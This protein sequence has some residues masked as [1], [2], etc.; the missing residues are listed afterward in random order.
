MADREVTIKLRA[1]SD[2]SDVTKNVQILREYFKQLKMPSDAFKGFDNTFTQLEKKVETVQAKLQAGFKTGSEINSFK[3]DLADI[4]QLYA[5][6]GK[7]IQNL[8]VSDVFKGID[9]PELIKAKENLEALQKTFQELSGQNI[10]GINKAF[11]ALTN[12]GGIDKA[13]KEVQELYDS[14][15]EG[16]LDQATQRIRE[17]AKAIAGMRQDGDRAKAYKG[18]LQNLVGT[19]DVNKILNNIDQVRER[20]NQTFNGDVLNQA[21][22]GIEATEIQIENLSAEQV[23]QLIKAFEDLGLVVRTGANKEL[24]QANRNL[25]E[26][27]EASKQLNTE[28]DQFKS[29]I[30]YFFGMNNAVRLFQ[31][32]LRSAFNTVKD[33]DKVM[34]ETAVVT[35]F[36]VGDMWS[37]LPEYTARA[38]ELGLAIHDVYEASTLYYQQGLK[39]NEV[40]AVTNATLRMARIA[41]LDAADATDRVTNALRGFNMEIT[42]ANA[43]NIADVYSKLA[44]M[45]ASNVDEISTAMTKVASLANNANMNFETTA[46]FLAQ[47]IETTRESAETAGTALKTVVARFSEVKKLYSEGELLGNDEEGEEIDVNKVSTALRTAGINLNEFLTGQRGLDEIFME[48]ASKWDDLTIVQQRYIATMAAG[49]RQQSR[50]I[51]LMSDYA[52]TQELVSAAQDA[53]GASQEQYEKTLDS[54]ETKLNRLKNAWDEFVMGLAKDEVIKWVVDALTSVIGAVNSLTAALPGALKSL[55]RLAIALTA[56]KGAKAIFNGLFKNIGTAMGMQAKNAGKESAGLF[57]NGFSGALQKL[58]PSVTKVSMQELETMGQE[59]R[60]AVVDNLP[61]VATQINQLFNAGNFDGAIHKIQEFGVQFNL[62]KDKV[63]ELIAKLKEIEAAQPKA[64]ALAQFNAACQKVGTTISGIGGSLLLIGQVLRSLGLDKA[65]DTLQKIGGI[66]L[67]VGLLIPKLSTGLFELGVKL[68]IITVQEIQA[69]NAALVAGGKMATGG[70][71]A[72]VAWGKLAIILAAIALVVT[73]IVLIINNLPDKKIQKLEEHLKDVEDAASEAVDKYN[74]LN[75]SIQSITEAED[76]LGELTQGTLEWKNAVLELN[77]QYL[78]LIDKIPVLSQF[79]QTQ[80]GVLHIDFDSAEVQEALD[81]VRQDAIERQMQV[82]LARQNVAKGTVDARREAL[83]N[84]YAHYELLPQKVLDN[85]DRVALA[86]AGDAEA[87]AYYQEQYGITR[88]GM[89]DQEYY[90]AIRSQEGLNTGLLANYEK[91][92]EYGNLLI[93]QGNEIEAQNRALAASIVSNSDL[94][95][96]QVEDATELLTG[97]VLEGLQSSVELARDLSEDEYKEYEEYWKKWAASQGY[98][99]SNVRNRGGVVYRDESGERHVIRAPQAMEQYNAHLQNTQ[100]TEILNS[101]SQTIASSNFNQSIARALLN[102]SDLVASDLE[103]ITRWSLTEAWES[104]SEEEQK[105]FEND[106]EAFG[107][108]VENAKTSLEEALSKSSEIGFNFDGLDIGQG[109]ISSLNTM[110]DQYQ[111]R[112]GAATASGFVNQINGILDGMDSESQNEFLQFVSGMTNWANQSIPGVLQEMSDLGIGFGESEDAIRLF[113]QQMIELDRTTQ[114]VSFEKIREEIEATAKVLQGLGERNANDRNFTQEEYDALKDLNSDLVNDM[115]WNGTEWTYIGSD[116]NSLEDAVREATGVLL[117]QDR[118]R[119]EESV[120]IGQ[121]ISDSIE[122]ANGGT[123]TSVNGQNFSYE[124]LY[125]GN[126]QVDQGL[127]AAARRQYLES[128]GLNSDEFARM[129]SQALADYFTTQM[130]TYYG[131]NGSV[132]AENQTTLDTITAQLSSAIANIAGTPLS[133]VQGEANANITQGTNDQN[134]A[135]ILA[136]AAQFGVA[137]EEIEEFNSLL[138]E[139]GNLLEGCEGRARELLNTITKKAGLAQAAKDMEAYGKAIHDNLD[140][141][142]EFEEGSREY[143]DALQEMTEQTER[144]FGLELPEDFMSAENLQLLTEA[145]EGSDQAWADYIENINAAQA[146]EGAW[147]DAAVFDAQ[148]VQTVAAAVDGTEINIDGTADVSDIITAMAQAGASA[149]EVANF[150]NELGYAHIDFQ[151][152]G[153]ES[154]EEVI[155]AGKNGILGSI[156]AV[157]VRVPNRNSFTSGA[158]GARGGSGGG[159]GGGSK[160]SWQNPYDELYNLTEKINESIRKRNQLEEEYDR[161]LNRRDGDYEA[162][163]KNT[164]QQISLLSKELALQQQLRAGRLSQLSNVGNEKF[165]TENGFKTY[166]EMGVTRYASYNA[167]TGLLEIDWDGINQ[168]EDTETGKAVEAYVK[169]LEELEGQIEDTDKT[170]SEI[171]DQIYDLRQEGKDEAVEMENRIAEALKNQQQKI[172]DEYQALSE[173]IADSNNKVLNSLQESIDLSRQIRD[174]TKTE[175]DIAEKEARLAYLKRDTSGAN[176]LEIQQLEQEI[177]DARQSYTDTLI[178]QSIDRLSS[179]NELAAEQRERQATIMQ[180]QLDYA[181]MTGEFTKQAHEEMLAAVD[182]GNWGFIIDL[183]KEDDGFKYLTEFAQELWLDDLEQQIQQATTGVHNFTNEIVDAVEEAADDVTTSVN[184][185]VDEVTS[186]SGGGGGGSGSVT[187]IAGLGRKI[188]DATD[189][190]VDKKNSIGKND[191]TK[192]ISTNTKGTTFETKGS[193]QN[194]EVKGSKPVTGDSTTVKNNTLSP[195]EQAKQEYQTLSKGITNSAI[196]TQI[197][198]AV[199]KKY[200]IKSTAFKSGGLADFTGPAWLD[201]S[202]SR[203]ELVLNARD[204]ENFIAL[205]NILAHLLNG[206]AGGANTNTSGEINLDIDINVDQIANDYDVD[207]LVERVKSNIYQDASYRNINQINFIR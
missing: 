60:A 184:E 97:V 154:M 1:I 31:R 43:N 177:S 81:T 152:S 82:A 113:V 131:T 30:T 203:P 167:S 202:K 2:I 66:M 117:Q 180:S 20:L 51:A 175:E 15:K 36:S 170:I 145:L 197:K 78:D 125:N 6:L 52:R 74:E 80:N 21:R 84:P 29:R 22:E 25:E 26:T 10:A 53:A 163:Y 119:L 178:D 187:S 87:M 39:T 90:R 28:L 93:E 126:D 182:S 198:D 32:A 114:K 48:L 41:G 179:E 194:T 153:F 185:G 176:M 35:E 161:I 166:A 111:S 155:T 157:N 55:S 34:T 206:Q 169:R 137:E 67:A 62:S 64:Q 109:I 142:N 159:G 164:L 95:A 162:L 168:I 37:Q 89:T 140:T 72:A 160:K 85:V 49:S 173:T 120:Q 5:T 148:E 129:T 181:E 172:I 108:W 171:S 58:W 207:R 100:G 56:F 8:N 188:D 191:N 110:F 96:S 201:G 102:S 192:N 7:D 47:I 139:S 70:N 133:M 11:E 138:D 123:I 76:A 33:L 135:G 141:I 13:R 200:G 190:I 158:G 204:T 83:Y 46:A 92:L 77:Q 132:L 199:A 105:L 174:N 14:L 122:Q 86:L 38:N 149:E 88:Q 63:E 205:R 65:A 59:F 75:D 127:L 112:F 186:G 165:E 196:L 195:A 4:K 124:D 146:A 9:S 44:A 189:T 16:N 136:S 19:D 73:T 128:I 45:S 103:Q 24:P 42:E 57:V 17:L 116:L 79:L 91:V 150:L 104:L 94:D 147:A 115:V 143:N 12:I 156:E 130:D 40:M 69:G 27:A 118:D 144:Y 99:L 61:A 106:P 151:A 54:L 71:I 121:A 101:L 134:V 23:E 107:Q 18:L 3:R 193:S 50:F 183:L 68:K 98:H